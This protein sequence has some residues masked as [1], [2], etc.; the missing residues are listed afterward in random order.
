MISRQQSRHEGSMAKF[1]HGYRIVI[2]EI[3]PI[4][5]VNKTVGIIVDSIS[6]DFIFVSPKVT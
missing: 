1:V 2:N 4:H 6:G 3:K 5:I